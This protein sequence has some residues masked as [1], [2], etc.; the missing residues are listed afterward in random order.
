M[1][2]WDTYRA[3]AERVTVEIAKVKGSRFIGEAVPVGSVEA[4]E[5]ELEGVRRREHSASHHSYAYRLRPDGSVFRYSDDGEPSGTAG[6][7]ILRQIDRLD[8]TDTLVV[9]TRYYGGTKLGTGG[10]IRAYGAA[11]AAVLEACRIQQHILRVPVGFRF[12]YADTSPALHTIRQ[13]DTEIS[14]TQYD[15]QTELTVAVRQSEVMALVEAFTQAL[16][17]RGSVTLPEE[18]S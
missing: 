17:G 4:V 5:I 6:M 1:S 10:L 14:A 18:D 9:V 16:G 13:Y 11:A 3:I 7:P 12:D 15:A 2:A 8:L